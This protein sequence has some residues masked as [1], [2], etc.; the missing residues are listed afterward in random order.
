M[1][2]WFGSFTWVDTAIL[3]VILL[4]TLVGLF[5]G[6]VREAISLLVWLAAIF[7]ALRFAEPAGALL[8]S[9][10]HSAELRFAMAFVAILIVVLVAGMILAALVRMLVDKT[11]LGLFDRLLGVFFGLA[12]GILLSAMLLL[13]VHMSSLAS[14]DAVK[15]AYLVGKMMPL[16][17]W[18]QGQIPEHLHRMS[19]WL[20]QHQVNQVPQLG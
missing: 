3:V 14:S 20:D 8:A 10:V 7:L 18:L 16:V 6:F 5:R 1:N 17:S 4:S 19:E 15:Q 9:H 11:G 2:A 12:R 13:F